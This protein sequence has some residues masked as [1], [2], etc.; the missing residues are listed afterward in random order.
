M[1]QKVA[2]CITPERSIESKMDVH[3]TVVRSV[4]RSRPDRRTCPASDKAQTEG[5][6]PQGPRVVVSSW[7]QALVHRPLAHEAESWRT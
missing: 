3:I 5:D 4:V 2:L 6:F 7:R 1:Y